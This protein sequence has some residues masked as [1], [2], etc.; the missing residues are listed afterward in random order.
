MV[1]ALVILGAGLCLWQYL[2]SPSLWLD[3]IAVARNI[4]DRSLWDLLISPLD[5]DQ[6]APKGFLLAEKLAVAAFGR[7]DYALRLVPV[8]SAL[9]AL[10]GFWRVTLLVLED[11]AAPVAVGL[12]VTAAPLVLFASTVKQYATDVAVA[13]LL[14]W[15]TLA[16][17]LRRLAP[18]AW[19]AGLVGATAVWCS[20]PA[21]IALGALGASLTVIGWQDGG[22]RRLR[23]LAPLL[24]IWAVSALAATLA[25][26]ASM[27]PATHAY[28]NQFWEAG[29]LP[30][31]PQRALAILWPL[32]QLIALFGTT[33]GS[34][35]LTYPVPALYV[36]LTVFGFW[37]LWRQQ[38]VVALILL[39]P[40]AGT[41]A[42]AIA[43]QYPFSDRLIVF[44]VP[45]F[46][47]AMATAIDWL[48]RMASRW[49]RSLGWL[50]VLL[51]VGPAASPMV[52]MP[53]AYHREDIRPVLA[54]LQTQWH[55]GDGVY[56]FQGAGP[57][58]TFYGTRYGLRETDYAVGGCYRED[59]RRYLDELDT[60]R[61]RP[62]VWLLLTHAIPAFRERENMLRYLDT[63][64]TRRDA[65]AVQPHLTGHR[66]LPAEVFLYDLSDPTRL[67]RATA[68]SFPIAPPS[69]PNARLV[70]SGGPDTMVPAHGL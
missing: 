43:R 52:A 30:A 25:A 66:G 44:L 59:G 42:A 11:G 12:F 38:R 33:L 16:I 61:G 26:M 2:A 63:I 23:T 68:S 1:Q 70:C 4:F 32:D 37:I 5:Y 3:E 29:F 35:A 10:V 39:A 24:G 40:I 22:A 18:R 31:S 9:T 50:V 21:I 27:T 46:F 67:G 69:S 62:R 49:S 34:G 36:M 60:F 17:A 57:A 64:G 58:V 55:A 53:P 28:M 56:V 19:A 41:L 65:F 47:L 7:N 14:L 6:V 20:Q 15:I 45:S 51:L 13:V 8:I 54:H 48:R